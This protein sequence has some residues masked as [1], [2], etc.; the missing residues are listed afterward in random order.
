MN[1]DIGDDP[2]VKFIPVSFGNKARLREAA[3]HD[4]R[5]AARQATE[6]RHVGY[7]IWLVVIDGFDE[8]PL[9]H[10]SVFFFVP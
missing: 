1:R 7:C 8:F 2:K 9:L 6:F 10:D 4:R 5:Y 3:I